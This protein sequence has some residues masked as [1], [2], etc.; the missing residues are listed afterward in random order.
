MIRTL[1]AVKS[2]GFRGV[3]WIA[4]VG[5]SFVLL[6]GVALPGPVHAEPGAQGSA[7]VSGV[8]SSGI[9][10][11]IVQRQT[12]AGSDLRG[13][14]DVVIPEPNALSGSTP[15]LTVD[16][17]EVRFLSVWDAEH[18]AQYDEWSQG[19]DSFWYYFLSYAVD[20]NTAMY[21]ATADHRYL[22]RALYYIN[23]VVAAARISSTLAGSQ[24][25]DQYL[26][27]ISTEDGN[28]EVV[29]RESVL[30]RYVTRLLLVIRQTPDLYF[31]PIY[32]AQYDSL[33]EFSEVQI[34]EKWYSR[35]TNTIFR[36]RTHMTAHWA[37]ITMDLW[38][39]TEDPERRALY[40]SIFTQIN[41][42]LRKQIIPN[43]VDP[44][45]YFWSDVWDS[46]DRPGQ[47][48]GHG[49]NVVSYMVEAFD[50]NM[51]WTA[52]DMTGLRNLLLNVLWEGDLQDPI[53]NGYLDGS[54]PGNGFDQGDGFVKLGR[55]FPE[56]QH[57]YENY[58]GLGRYMTQIYGNAALNARI[59]ALNGCLEG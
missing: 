6:L 44:N 10:Q 35:S 22:D 15:L 58:V 1:R 55:Y 27:W 50:Q 18:E 51:F 38:Q 42:N 17:W 53:F 43:P 25:H 12:L 23:N 36:I 4:A 19:N 45:A 28:Q 32:R 29:L 16:D 57:M 34:F 56:V 14:S 24:Y 13:Q 59:L 9:C 31:D 47:D 8:P 37:Y 41:E 48:T 49:N 40:Q 21:L 26:G 39:L 2:P 11:P 20:G 30:W 52:D 3:A 7:G 33:L 46:Y 54:D 5:L